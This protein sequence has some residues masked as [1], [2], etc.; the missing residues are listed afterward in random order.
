[1]AHGFN[2]GKRIVKHFYLNVPTVETAG[3]VFMLS[4][5]LAIAHGLNFGKYIGS[6]LL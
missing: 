5:I 2:R 3:S 1:M 4:F 6:L